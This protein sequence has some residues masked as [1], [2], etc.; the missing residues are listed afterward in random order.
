MKFLSILF[1]VSSINLFASEE[2]VG[3]KSEEFLTTLQSVNYQYANR[4]GTLK[5]V[6]LTNKDSEL[7][8]L[9]SSE[10]FARTLE[11]AQVSKIL[12]E[13]IFQSYIEASEV[14]SKKYSGKAVM[15]SSNGNQV[16]E[17]KD[18]DVVSELTCNNKYS[19]V[20]RT[21][22][23]KGKLATAFIKNRPGQDFTDC[24]ITMLIYQNPDKSQVRLVD[25][26]VLQSDHRYQVLLPGDSIDKKYFD[27]IYTYK[28]GSVSVYN[29][30]TPKE[31]Y[32]VQYIYEWDILAAM[33][34]SRIDTISLKHRRRS[35][36]S[37]FN[38]GTEYLN[39]S[40]ELD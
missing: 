24:E 38:P 2:V 13:S 26:N 8:F 10:V 22:K 39:L 37:F 35:S 36:L 6:S 7:P 30:Y 28:D 25:F 32:I 23:H 4:L 5:N 20:V 29:S 1:L 34:E 11:Q 21:T 15:L 33:Q 12:C 14:S 31:S 3:Q 9:T 18:A 16:V 19:K 27:S 40:C 17:V